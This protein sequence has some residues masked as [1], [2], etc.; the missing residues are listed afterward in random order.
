MPGSLAPDTH[1]QLEDRHMVLEG[2]RIPYYREEHCSL[3]NS[4]CSRM[5]AGTLDTGYSHHNSLAGS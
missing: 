5:A 4:H 3:G 1:I 2:H